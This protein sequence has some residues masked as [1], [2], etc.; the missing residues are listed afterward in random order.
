ML[1]PDGPP[2]QIPFRDAAAPAATPAS[3]ALDLTPR[4]RAQRRNARHAAAPG[5][6]G[7][8]IRSAGLARITGEPLLTR[9]LEG[10][11][12]GAAPT[13]RSRKPPP[14]PI[15]GTSVPMLVEGECLGVLMVTSREGTGTTIRMRL[16]LPVDADAGAQP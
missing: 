1:L 11:P 16:P 9:A 14:V 10:R 13:R 8:D 6:R 3:L 4:G 15:T 2:D 7:S 12:R 5:R